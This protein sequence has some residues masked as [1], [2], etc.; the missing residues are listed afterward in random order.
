MRQPV[1]SR[2]SFPSRCRI[3]RQPVYFGLFTANLLQDIA[4]AST[5]GARKRKSLQDMASASKFRVLA[6]AISCKKVLADGIS[7]SISYWLTRYPASTWKRGSQKC[8]L[9]AN[10]AATLARWPPKYWLTANPALTAL[11]APTAQAEGP[12]EEPKG[13]KEDTPLLALNM[14]Q[15]VPDS[16][17]LICH[18]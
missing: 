11:N 1:L 18:N 4:S 6:D 17:M 8:W 2:P 9:T 16:S 5:F 12:K 7:C 10:P 13:T 14:L 15:D 3:S